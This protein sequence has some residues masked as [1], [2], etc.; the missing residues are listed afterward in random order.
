M[1]VKFLPVIQKVLKRTWDNSHILYTYDIF[2]SKLNEDHTSEKVSDSRFRN[3]LKGYK[4]DKESLIIS[5]EEK[6]KKI[7][8]SSSKIK[9]VNQ[10]MNIIKKY[11]DI[12]VLAAKIQNG[13]IDMII[14]H[15]LVYEEMI[16]KQQVNIHYKFIGK[17]TTE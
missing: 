1:F 8:E 15:E 3:L 7:I 4:E 9:N 2:I 10:F 5:N 6:S 12:K 17:L 11:T 14:V 13:F 16:R